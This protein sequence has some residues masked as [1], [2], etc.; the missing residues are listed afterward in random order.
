M[1]V[2]TPTISS[3]H[4]FLVWNLWN[5][6]LN[7]IH[8]FIIYVLPEWDGTRN[9]YF[10]LSVFVFSKQGEQTGVLGRLSGEWVLDTLPRGSVCSLLLSSELCSRP[11]HCDDHA[12]VTCSRVCCP[13]FQGV[14]REWIMFFFNLCPITFLSPGTSYFNSVNGRPPTWWFSLANLYSVKGFGKLSWPKIRVNGWTQ[15]EARL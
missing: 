7:I 14:Q 8:N 6:S 12:V 9:M 5:Q 15:K 2:Y 1:C 4:Y 3:K 10:F 11:D 13:I